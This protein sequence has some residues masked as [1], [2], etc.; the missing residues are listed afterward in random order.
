MQ[1]EKYSYYILNID[2]IYVTYQLSSLLQKQC[3]MIFL[4]CSVVLPTFTNKQNGA[5]FAYL[6]NEAP[7]S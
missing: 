7:S 2:I 6:P 4:P 3:L 1:L 5:C